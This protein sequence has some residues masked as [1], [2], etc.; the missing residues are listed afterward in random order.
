MVQM[1]CTPHFTQNPP[2]TFFLSRT[3][4]RCS[5]DAAEALDLWRKERIGPNSEPT[6]PR[7]QILWSRIPEDAPILKEYSDPAAGPNSPHFEIT[8]SVRALFELQE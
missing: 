7:H 4:P 1:Q 5:I 8:L 3:D 2:I 6:G